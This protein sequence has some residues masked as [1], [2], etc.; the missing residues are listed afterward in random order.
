MKEKKIFLRAEW[1]NL[2]MVNHLVDPEILKPYIPPATEL[3]LW[4]GRT[5]VTLVGFK[6]CNTRIK[7]VKVP[8]HVNFEE[9]NLRFYNRYKGRDGTWKRGV[10]FFREIVPKYA[11]AFIANTFYNEHYKRMPTRFEQ[12]LE[13]EQ[14]KVGYYWKSDEWNSLE[15]KADPELHP[16]EPGTEEAFIAEHYWG[17]AKIGER[18][19]SEY[20]V[21]HPSWRL[22]SVKDHHID[23]D[24]GDCF[25]KEFAHLNEDPPSSVFLAEGSGVIIRHRSKIR[26]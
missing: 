3:D 4:N 5:Y 6:F 18:T 22:H 15:L 23:V 10:V 20:Q 17:Y 16:I 2:A 24:Y 13:E 11:V 12:R 9:I 8:F 19:S 14:L 25:G 26:A 7:G 1:R 21:E